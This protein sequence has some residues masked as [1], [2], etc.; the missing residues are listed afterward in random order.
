MERWFVQ[1]DGVATGPFD[2][3]ALNIRIGSRELGP[4]TKVR[5]EGDP[6]GDEAWTELREVARFK[7]LLPTS[8]AASAS[9]R[10]ALAP[11]PS[12]GGPAPISSAPLTPAAAPTPAAVAPLLEALGR[13]EER[14]RSPSHEAPVPTSLQAPSPFETPPPFE[15]PAPFEAPPPMV[16]PAPLE[17]P[18]APPIRPFEV[19]PR[20]EAAPPPEPAPEPEPA[21]PGAFPRAEAPG[22][23]SWPQYGSAAAAYPQR[24]AA[25]RPAPQAAPPP[26]RQ[27]G[28]Q[29]LL[30]W[31]FA[32]A[33]ASLAF[34][35]WRKHSGHRVDPTAETTTAQPVA[36]APTVTP[37][38]PTVPPA[39][40]TKLAT[41]DVTKGTGPAV[42]SGDRVRVYYTGTLTD[43]TEFDTTRGKDAFEFTLGRGYVIKGW[44]QG[45]VG[46][47]VGG[48]RRLT[49]PPSL[50][51]GARKMTGIPANST[52]NFDVE[53]VA[54]V[55]P[56][57]GRR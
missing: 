11:P 9:P 16:I 3:N 53:L 46:M 6:A 31:F 50:G 47:K 5:L 43:G 49:I 19:A 18:A 4:T 22:A 48:K 40:T 30:P 33:A 14:R 2:G 26:R 17:I 24:A 1:V 54:I 23:P 38:A 56:D 28:G 8:F 57:A 51:Y 52:L 42:K 35:G 44:D 41:V 34:A 45:I 37:T 55:K 36:A 21:P 7:R 15:M 29:W 20:T 25:R 12:L 13:I 39:S 27:A 10:V 32:L